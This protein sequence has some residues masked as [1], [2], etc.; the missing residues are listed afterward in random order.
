MEQGKLAGG[1]A[2]A[3]ARH[4]H[5]VGQGVNNEVPDL[6][7]RIQ[8]GLLNIME[9]KDVQIRGFPVRL[10]IDVQMI[11]T[12]NP[13]DYTNRGSI[14]TPLK[15]RIDSQILTH[16]P[17]DLGEARTITDAWFAE[18]SR[19]PV[20]NAGVLNGEVA[21]AFFDRVRFDLA[22]ARAAEQIGNVL[23]EG[24]VSKPAVSTGKESAFREA[25]AYLKGRRW[26]RSRR[27]RAR[28]RPP[29]PA[30]RLDR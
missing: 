17:R 22:I 3:L 10:P 13:E 24:L 20:C 5:H 29:A 23:R 11:F 30:S 25:A 9:E 19:P 2:Q 7:P 16:Y 1:Q 6:Q 12:A 4:R 27:A 14:I 28:R 26:R 15:D 8:V 18:R 21:E